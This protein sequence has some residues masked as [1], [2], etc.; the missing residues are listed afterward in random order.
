MG[1]VIAL[2][3]QFLPQILAAVN[4]P[5]VQQ[6]LPL[7]Q[8]LLQQ[9]GSAQFPGVDPTKAPAAGASLFDSN[10]TKWTQTALNVLG[11]APALTV[12]GSYGEATQAAVSAFQTANKL[13]VDG[14]AGTAT[15]DALRA[16][17]AKPKPA[18]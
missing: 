17:L 7:I 5:Q 4:N 2:L 18:A 14:W 12:D 13:V 11:A 1:S 9:L 3:V 10:A 6:F 16:A 15:Q 8:Q